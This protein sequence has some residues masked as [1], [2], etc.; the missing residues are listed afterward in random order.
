MVAGGEG[1]HN[2]HHTFPWDYRTAELGMPFNLTT[3][4]IDFLASI[5][6]VYER[7]T[8]SETT[9]TLKW[10]RRTSTRGR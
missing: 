7:K 3:H 2:Y 8:V 10:E 9:S 5:G 6:Q 1:W 4:I